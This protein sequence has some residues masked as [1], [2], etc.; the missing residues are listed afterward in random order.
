MKPDTDPQE[1]EIR[2]CFIQGQFS[3]CR[4]LYTIETGMNR[5]LYT[6]QRLSDGRRFKIS[7]V[8]IR[9]LSNAYYQD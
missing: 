8:K 1:G 5:T 6:V 7:R 2:D 4:I 9:K 3:P